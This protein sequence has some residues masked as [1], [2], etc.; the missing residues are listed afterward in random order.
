M[1]IAPQIR[2]NSTT[3]LLLGCQSTGVRNVLRRICFLCFPRYPSLSAMSL[4]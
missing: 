2:R 1:V 3:S 4:L